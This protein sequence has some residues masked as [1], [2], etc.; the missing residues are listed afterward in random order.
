[1]NEILFSIPSE[2]IFAVFRQKT[3]VLEKLIEG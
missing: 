2:F 3:P 1:M